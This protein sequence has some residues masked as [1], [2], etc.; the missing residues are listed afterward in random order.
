M[1][2]KT[3]NNITIVTV[4]LC[5]VQKHA[6]YEDVRLPKEVFSYIQKNMANFSPSEM[7]PA[8]RVKNPTVTVPQVHRAWGTISENTWKLDKDQ[9]NSA[10]LFI[11]KMEKE[12]ALLDLEVEEGVEQVA[13]VNTCVDMRLKGKIVEVAIDATCECKRLGV[14]YTLLICLVDNTNNKH[15]ELYSLMAEHDNA[16]FPISYCLLSTEFVITHGK[17][18][19]ALTKWAAALRDTCNIH[20]EF[21]HTDKD[22][23]EVSMSRTVWPQAKHQ[24]CWWHLERA[25]RQRMAKSKLSTSPYIGQRVHSIFNFVDPTFSP[26]QQSDPSDI[27]GGGYDDDGV[28]EL[29]V[30]AKGLTINLKPSSKLS[31]AVAEGASAHVE[32]AQVD[33][34][35]LQSNI[36]EL[37]QFQSEVVATDN[38][39]VDKEAGDAAWAKTIHRVML[40]VKEPATDLESEKNTSETNLCQVF[41]REEYRNDVIQLVEAHMNAHPFIPGYAPPDP[42]S[43][44][45]WAVEQM[46]QFC[47]KHNLVEMWAYMWSN[48]YRPSRWTLWAR[49]YHP[50]AIAILKTTM[51]CES[52]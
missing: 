42:S 8:I 41:C 36:P 51:I 5:H 20:P 2:D 52:Q 7:M 30:R 24:L 19:Q 38:M 11:A 39:T 50:K 32:V 22:M 43:I 9:I 10:R 48:W 35:Q 40:I 17:R 23:A 6:S 31:R 28:P 4:R 47:H 18:K 25:I 49:S 34:Q 14:A 44:Y 16:G 3:D 37:W 12:L 45:R 27:E 21:V 33:L 29:L 15:L 1:F 46:Y 26:T 13:W